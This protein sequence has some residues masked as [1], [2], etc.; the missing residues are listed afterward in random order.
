MD[1]DPGELEGMVRMEVRSALASYGSLAGFGDGGALGQ[2]VASGVNGGCEDVPPAAPAAPAAAT[3]E[4]FDIAELTTSITVENCWYMKG[5]LY[6]EKAA[7][8]AYEVTGT[9][10]V[11]VCAVFDTLTGAV[12]LDQSPDTTQPPTS[13]YIHVPIY[14]LSRATG[15]DNWRV[16]HDLRTGLIQLN[17]YV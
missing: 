16:T 2:G 3:P 6:V 14:K 8:A 13:R 10:T 12:T 7:P 1:I 15:D 4:P 17:A 5:P 9:G 11:T